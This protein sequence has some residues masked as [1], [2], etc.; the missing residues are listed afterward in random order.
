MVSSKKKSSNTWN[1][2]EKGLRDISCTQLVLLAKLYN[3]S[4]DYIVE[5]SDEQGHFDGRYMSVNKRLKY[6]RRQFYYSESEIASYLSCSA[7]H[8]GRFE[9][10]ERK[11]PLD[12]LILLAKK[13]NVSVDY[14]LLGV[15][16]TN[17]SS[18]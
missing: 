9:N 16:N 8:Y 14:L 13:Y 2:I 10:G 11:I 1:V 12:M 17:C 5:L 4:C 6:L 15:R 18:Q 7:Q 3:V